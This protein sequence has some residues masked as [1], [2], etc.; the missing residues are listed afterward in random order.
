VTESR[1][2]STAIEIALLIVGAV[3]AGLLIGASL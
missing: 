3:V 1:V 2:M